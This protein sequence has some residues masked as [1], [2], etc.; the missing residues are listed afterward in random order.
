MT[1]LSRRGMSMGRNKFPFLNRNMNERQ[2]VGRAIDAFDALR[3]EAVENIGE[4]TLDEINEE[5]R[6]SRAERKARQA[7]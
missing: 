3:Q 1:S 7:K 6:A 2:A 4:M 5:I